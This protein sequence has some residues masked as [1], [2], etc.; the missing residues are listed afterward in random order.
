MTE[1]ERM[2][3]NDQLIG[4]LVDALEIVKA[5]CRRCESRMCMGCCFDSFARGMIPDNIER[6]IAMMERL[7]S[8]KQ[9]IIA[10]ARN[11]VAERDVKWE[12]IS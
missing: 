10:L 9:D 12:E 11:Y 8:S 1:E 4:H 2:K 5:K 7:P 3:E 6:T